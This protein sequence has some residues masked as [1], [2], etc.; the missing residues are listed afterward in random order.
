MTRM[1][2]LTTLIQHSTGSHSQSNQ[3]RERNKRHLNCEGRNKTHFFH[4]ML[5]TLLFFQYN[6]I[7]YAIR[8]VSVF[9]ICLPPPSSFIPS[10]N[11]PPL[12]SCPWVMHIIYLDILFPIL[13]LTSP[14]LF[15]TYNLYFLIPES[16]P[17]FSCFPLPADDPSNHL[18]MILFLF[19]FLLSLFFKFSC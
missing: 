14:C 3:A 6:F 19:C 5:L 12:S 9:P 15:F 7:D 4:M 2:T 11:T 13:F 8:V 1:P 17:P 10:S 16:F 18:P